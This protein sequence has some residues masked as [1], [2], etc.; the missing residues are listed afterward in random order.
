MFDNRSRTKPFMFI[1]YVL[2]AYMGVTT[3]G[4]AIVGV[5]AAAIYLSAKGQKLVG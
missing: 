1:G 4:L 2:F 3:I 5:A